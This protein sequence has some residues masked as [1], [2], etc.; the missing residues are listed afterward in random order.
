MEEL[1]GVSLKLPADKKKEL[2]IIAN[3][4]GIGLAGLVRMILY[5]YLSDHDTKKAA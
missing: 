2:D 5:G 4:K 1:I 3:E